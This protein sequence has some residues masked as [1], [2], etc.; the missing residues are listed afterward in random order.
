MKTDATACR[1]SIDVATGSLPLDYAVLTSQMCTEVM[2]G[3][4]SYVNPDPVT[5]ATGYAF[6][7][8]DNRMVLVG[9]VTVKGNARYIPSAGGF[10]FGIT[11]PGLSCGVSKTEGTMIIASHF[12]CI[13]AASD[14]RVK[15]GLTFDRAVNAPFEAPDGARDCH[16]V[17]NGG[18]SFTLDFVDKVPSV[19]G[20]PTSSNGRVRFRRVAA[21]LYRLIDGESG[22]QSGSFSVPGN[23]LTIFHVIEFVPERAPRSGSR[24]QDT[25]PAPVASPATGVV[26]SPSRPGDWLFRHT[27]SANGPVFWQFHR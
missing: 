9:K 21:G 11:G 7:G 16:A 3:S 6:A 10:V 20:L 13:V 15:D 8:Q 25:D 19:G 26:R 2:D 12:V 18:A 24:R 17:G 14:P 4:I 22:T 1:F 27:R 23:G 5:G